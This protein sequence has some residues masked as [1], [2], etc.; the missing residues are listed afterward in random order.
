MV[1]LEV[2]IGEKKRGNARRQP[3][4]SAPRTTHLFLRRSK[5]ETRPINHPSKVVHFKLPFVLDTR[6]ICSM[7]A[8]VHSVFCDG[9]WSFRPVHIAHRHR[10][11]PIHLF[12]A[13]FFPFTRESAGSRTRHHPSLALTPCPLRNPHQVTTGLASSESLDSENAGLAAEQLAVKVGQAKR[14]SCPCSS[15]NCGDT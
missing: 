5:Q 15:V 2:D 6:K 1:R 4:T 13:Q 7:C 9:E 14:G 8:T 12:N 10:I 3:S 11:C